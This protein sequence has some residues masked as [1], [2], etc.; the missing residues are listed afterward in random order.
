MNSKLRNTLSA[1]TVALS[2]AAL[3][4][5]LGEPVKPTQA[6]YSLSSS[7]AQALIQNLHDS[8][9]SAKILNANSAE[10]VLELQFEAAAKLS[11]IEI[12]KHW[13]ANK[14]DATAQLPHRNSI[15]RHEVSMPYFSFGR[16]NR[17][18]ST[19]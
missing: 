8:Q 1:L 4:F 2:F 9:L 18:R 5:T 7:L 12:I 6:E 19:L 11:L 10:Q 15:L 14:S 13:D 17:V 3:G 16:I